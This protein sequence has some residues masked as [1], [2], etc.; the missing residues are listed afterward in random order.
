MTP[1]TMAGRLKSRAAARGAASM[2]TS[3]PAAGDSGR[4]WSDTTIES[5]RSPA[6]LQLCGSLTALPA[7][8]RT[9]TGASFEA[10]RLDRS[11]IGRKNG[12]VHFANTLLR[13]DGMKN[14]PAAT[15]V[16]SLLALAMPG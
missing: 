16:F 3:S 14:R 1:V 9:L 5:I 8:L 2:V 7:R 10:R 11:R 13:S 4:A 12:G 6:Q 15:I